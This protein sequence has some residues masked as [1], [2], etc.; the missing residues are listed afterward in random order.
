MMTIIGFSAVG[1]LEHASCH[2]LPY[3]TIRL[4][5][6]YTSDTQHPVSRTRF[7]KQLYFEQR[8][9]TN[10]QIFSLQRRAKTPWINLYHRH[11]LYIL[12]S[13]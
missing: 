2:L 4:H 8:I 11:T 9:W 7:S 1:I 13:F 12:G 3:S 10:P 6:P 5:D